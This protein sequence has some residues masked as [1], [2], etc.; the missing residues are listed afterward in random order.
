MRWDWWQAHAHLYLRACVYVC[1]CVHVRA[2]VCAGMIKWC[3]TRL[4]CASSSLVWVVAG[5]KYTHVCVI[6]DL[7]NDCADF[8]ARQHRTPVLAA[9]PIWQ[10][11]MTVQN[12]SSKWQFKMTAQNDSSKWQFETT[13][14]NDSSKWQLKMTVQNVS[15]CGTTKISHFDSHVLS[16]SLS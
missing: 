9:R 11:K 12:D 4:L 3:C 14:Q 1:V 5:G 15:F 8:S 16:N 6:G 13:A 7:I 2:S 10:F